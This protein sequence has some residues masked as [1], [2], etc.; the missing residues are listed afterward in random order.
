MSNEPETSR[1]VVSAHNANERHSSSS[2]RSSSG[3]SDS[4]VKF[5]ALGDWQIWLCVS[6]IVF[7]E[8][9]DLMMYS[10]KPDDSIGWQGRNIVSPLLRHVEDYAYVEL[11]KLDKVCWLPPGEIRDSYWVI[12]RNFVYLLYETLLE[13]RNWDENV[14]RLKELRRTLPWKL[15]MMPIPG[16]TRYRVFRGREIGMPVPNG[17]TPGIGSLIHEW[18]KIVIYVIKRI[19]EYIWRQVY[20]LDLAAAAGTQRPTGLRPFISILLTIYRDYERQQ[21]VDYMNGPRLRPLTRHMVDEVYAFFRRGYIKGIDGAAWA[22][23][24]QRRPREDDD[25]GGAAY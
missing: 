25:D 20:V 17:I 2:S 23:R 7:D 10:D 18:P 3:P 1:P 6:P 21:S 11:D 13:L 16:Y 5:Y 22:S 4:E 14:P 15:V 12:G 8:M 24:R 9:L 19:E